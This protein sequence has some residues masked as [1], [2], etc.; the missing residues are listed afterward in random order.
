MS[1][2]VR[3]KGINKGT[4]EVQGL[5]GFRGKEGRWQIDKQEYREE[6]RRKKGQERK[7]DV[8]RAK[9]NKRRRKGRYE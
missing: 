9:R 6:N 2:K 7:D 3:Q 5:L 1:I 4:K 8:R